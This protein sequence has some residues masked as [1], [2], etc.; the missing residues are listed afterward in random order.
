MIPSVSKAWQQQQ[1]SRCAHPQRVTVGRQSST[2]PPLDLCLGYLERVQPTLWESLPP[3]VT[4][5]QSS[6]TDSLV[7]YRSDQVDNQNQSLYLSVLE[8]VSMH[9]HIGGCSCPWVHMQRPEGEARCLSHLMH[10]LPTS[11]S[12]QSLKSRHNYLWGMAFKAK[13]WWIGVPL[14][15][16]VMFVPKPH[17]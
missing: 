11:R 9:M 16:E 6:F 5:P 17:E 13:I 8:G 10:F 15:M 7:D 4:L 3:P 14:F 2:F 1:Q 12:I